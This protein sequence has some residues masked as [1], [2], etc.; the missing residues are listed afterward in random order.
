[1]YKYIKSSE[2]IYAAV[3]PETIKVIA[4]VIGPLVIELITKYWETHE[5]DMIEDIADETVDEI[6]DSNSSD[7][8]F[9]MLKEFINENPDLIIETLQQLI[10]SYIKDAAKA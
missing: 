4:E 3:N 8:K 1:M 6:N 5:D 10:P 2:E 7:E 9:V